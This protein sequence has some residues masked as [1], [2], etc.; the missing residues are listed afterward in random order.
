VIIRNGAGTPL[1]GRVVSLTSSGSSLLNGATAPQSVTTDSSGVARFT[2]TDTEAESVVLSARDVTASPPVDLATTQTVMFAL[3]SD[4]ASTSTVIPNATVV[5]ADATSAVTI[6]VHLVNHSSPVVGSLV[7]L[8]QGTG[9][10]V[11]ASSN[12]VSGADGTVSFTLTDAVPEAIVLQATDVTTGTLLEAVPVVH[13]TVPAGGSIVPTITAVNPNQGPGS[14]GSLVQ[15]LGTNF[16]SVTK[17]TF[18]GA[19]VLTYS[20]L[21]SSEIDVVVPEAILAGSVDITVTTPNGSSAPSP[22]DVYTY[23][24]QPPMHVQ[25]LSPSWMLVAGGKQVTLHGQHLTQLVKLSVNGAVVPFSVNPVGGTVSF[26]APRQAHAGLVPVVLVG[27]SSTTSIIL[28]FVQPTDPPTTVPPVQTQ[29]QLAVVLSAQAATQAHGV[30]S[31]SI[32]GRALNGVHTVSLNGVRATH[33]V[34]NRDGSMVHCSVALGAAPK[35]AAILSL[36]FSDGS[37]RS[38]ALNVQAKVHGTTM[39]STQDEH[40]KVQPKFSRVLRAEVRAR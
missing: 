27:R 6:V 1:A 16:S 21:S 36:T 8:R 37:S 38:L 15:L 13:F 23:T 20:I 33:V 14:G 9:H 30:L 31:V 11:I 29:A 25:G 24:S 4:E 3:R 2:V 10:A 26:E 22:S 40:P 17:I 28:D 18:G 7:S 32:A 35:G 12:P 34:A 5:S 19:R 39:F